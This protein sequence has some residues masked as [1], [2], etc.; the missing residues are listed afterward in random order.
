MKGFRDALSFLTIIPV[1]GR[2][3]EETARSLPYFPLVGALLAGIAY[4]FSFLFQHVLPD[5]LVGVMTFGFLQVLTGLH[6]SDGLLDIGDAFM[7]HGSKERKRAVMHDQQIGIGGFFLVFMVFTMTGVSMGA[8]L[9][10]G[11]F[12][13]AVVSSEVAATLS[14]GCVAFFGRSSHEGMGSRFIETIT[15]RSFI[16]TMLLSGIILTPFLEIGGFILGL[17]IISSYILV[18]IAERQ[19]GGVGGDFLG[20]SHD[21]VRM[22]SL[23]GILVVIG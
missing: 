13:S 14:M 11:V 8:L 2:T 1:R 6:H 21:I 5:L 16:G 23:V 18:K 7:V 10:S 15:P 3:L 12:F 19:F 4:L 9:H 17:T 22:I 20:A